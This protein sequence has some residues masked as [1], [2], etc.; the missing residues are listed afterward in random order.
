[1]YDLC[2]VVL[3][4]SIL[5]LVRTLQSRKQARAAPPVLPAAPPSTTLATAATG[6]AVDDEARG[7]VSAQ[8]STAAAGV[9]GEAA[10]AAAIGGGGG[11]GG[12]EEPPTAASTAAPTIRGVG[13]GL[14]PVLYRTAVGAITG[15]GSAVTGTSGPVVSMPMLLLL[16][17]PIHMSLGSA[18][19][20]TRI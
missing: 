4:S 10:T 19:A 18:Q 9:P 3:L 6:A 12:S 15:F 17:W 14:R 16:R 13:A 11:E 2:A 8:A 20:A 5:A 7:L 1:M